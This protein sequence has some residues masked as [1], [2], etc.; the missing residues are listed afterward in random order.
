MTQ[1]TIQLD[2]PLPL[3]CGETLPNRL[4]KSAMTEGCADALGRATEYRER[5]LSMVI[6]PTDNHTM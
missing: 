3:P 4:G 2:T 6:T 5:W 1:T